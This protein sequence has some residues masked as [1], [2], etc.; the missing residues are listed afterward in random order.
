MEEAEVDEFPVLLG[1]GGGVF[2][3]VNQCIWTS[4]LRFSHG[5]EVL[6]KSNLL[7]FTPIVASSPS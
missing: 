2:S 4:A 5:R 3:V 1:H 7:Y 6:I